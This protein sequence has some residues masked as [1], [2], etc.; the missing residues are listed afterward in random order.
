MLLVLVLRNGPVLPQATLKIP[1]S[2]TRILNASL[3]LLGPKF[4]MS[5]TTWAKLCELLVDVLSVLFLTPLQYS[6]LRE[7]IQEK[8]L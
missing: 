6:A 5:P 3:H 4:L 7:D 2:A 1:I 8:M